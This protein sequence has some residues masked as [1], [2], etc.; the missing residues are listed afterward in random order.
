MVSYLWFADPASLPRPDNERVAGRK[1]SDSH[2][3]APHGRQVSASSVLRR[4]IHRP[5]ASMGGPSTQQM[6]RVVTPSREQL[7]PSERFVSFVRTILRTTQVSQSV[8]TLSLFY[9]YRLKTRRENLRGQPGSEFRLFLTSLILANKFLDDHTYTNKT[10]SD[11]SR[12]ALKEITRMEQQLWSGIGMSASATPTEFRWWQGTLHRLK[13]QRALDL[14]L[15]AWSESVPMINYAP[16]P[17]SPIL[18]DNDTSPASLRGGTLHEQPAGVLFYHGDAALARAN[19]YARVHATAP[20]SAPPGATVDA[21]FAPGFYGPQL[22][23]VPFAATESRSSLSPSST[24][25]TPSVLLTPCSTLPNA[26]LEKDAAEF[27]AS[28]AHMFDAMPMLPAATDPALVAAAHAGTPYAPMLGPPAYDPD[29]LLAPSHLSPFTTPTLCGGGVPSPLVLHYYRLAA[30]YSRGIPA[31]G[32]IDRSLAHSTGMIPGCVPMSA[33]PRQT[34]MGNGAPIPSA[35]LPEYL[36]MSPAARMRSG[37]RDSFGAAWHPPEVHAD[38]SGV[39]PAVSGGVS[40]DIS[41]HPPTVPPTDYAGYPPQ[42]QYL[43]PNLLQVPAPAPGHGGIP[44]PLRQSTANAP[45]Q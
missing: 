19:K 12:I 23:A 3:H 18:R 36:G 28:Q 41:P 45:H 25:P 29:L 27:T 24:V 10:W 15:L 22:P 13:M 4:A 44:S 35:G 42:A 32:H 14:Q 2:T 20:S 16:S 6:D 1:R 39:R 37:R 34:P 26:A 43:Q 31:L 11:V 21:S 33:G 7:C 8:I 30:G 5:T 40:L 38:A 17:A 9:I